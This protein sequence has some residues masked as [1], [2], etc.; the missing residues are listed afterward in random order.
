MGLCG[1]TPFA[2]SCGCNASPGGTNLAA[3]TANAAH[4][5]TMEEPTTTRANTPLPLQSP[6]AT[7]RRSERLSV[8]VCARRC[9][10]RRTPS[11]GKA[12]RKRSATLPHAV[13]AQARPPY[14][15]YHRSTDD[16][17]TPATR[18]NAEHTKVGERSSPQC[19]KQCSRASS[20]PSERS[21]RMGATRSWADDANAPAL[22]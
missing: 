16:V 6:S 9:P 3:P 11:W 12:R 15:D 22:P 18:Q 2:S 17:K 20:R 4:R 1:G 7:H 19:Q 21:V 14:Q 8:S 10:S 5:T 13:F